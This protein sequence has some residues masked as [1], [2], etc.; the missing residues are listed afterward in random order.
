[1]AYAAKEDIEQTYPEITT[2]VNDQSE[3]IVQDAEEA[4]NNAIAASHPQSIIDDLTT[5]YTDAQ[6]T[7]ETKANAVISQHLDFAQDEID[8][9]IK[10]RYPRTWVT[11][12]STL[13]R[14]SVDI[15]V[16]KMP[17]EAD[18]R[19]DEMEKRY[20]LAIETLEKIQNGMLD[21]HDGEM[22]ALEE[23]EI[24]PINTGA[25]QIGSWV[26]R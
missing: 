21:L 4:L 11:V 14:L 24:A 7:A 6:N 2:L 8:L 3:N 5:A 23:D 12:P 13:K 25:M 16:Y 19:T 18:W 10:S 22:E 15:A 20:K 17:I 9:Y 1:M 26:R